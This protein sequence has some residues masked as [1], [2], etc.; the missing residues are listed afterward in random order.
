[1]VAEQLETP[2][3]EQWNEIANV[4]TVRRGIK[5]AIEHDGSAAESFRQLDCISAIRQQL[6]LPELIEHIHA[7]GSKRVAEGPLKVI[8]RTRTRLNNGNRR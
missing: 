7:A 2:Q 8:L 3:P 6:A 5:T 4:Q 1:M